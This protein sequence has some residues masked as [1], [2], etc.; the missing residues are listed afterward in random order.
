MEMEELKATV[1]YKEQHST[2][3]PHTMVN[4]KHGFE[5]PIE[6]LK[7]IIIKKVEDSDQEEEEG[8]E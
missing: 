2:L 8:S 3:Q 7:N 6:G 5:I 4:A 1:L